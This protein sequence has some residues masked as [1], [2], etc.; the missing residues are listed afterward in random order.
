M[1]VSAIYATR[2]LYEVTITDSAGCT[3]TDA[4]RIHE[5]EPTVLEIEAQKVKAGVYNS[6][7]VQVIIKG[8]SDPYLVVWNNGVTG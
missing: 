8:N 6:G 4:T 5:A 3:L 7:S 2:G 1:S